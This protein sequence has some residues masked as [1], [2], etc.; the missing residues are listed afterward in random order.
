[1]SLCLSTKKRRLVILTTKRLSHFIP[2]DLSLQEDQLLLF[3]QY[4]PI[5]QKKKPKRLL[6]VTTLANM[7]PI[8]PDK[9]LFVAGQRKRTTQICPIYKMCTNKGD[10]QRLWGKLFNNSHFQYTTKPPVVV[11]PDQI[12]KFREVGE[13][14]IQGLFF[15]TWI[16]FFMVSLLYPRK[17]DQSKEGTKVQLHNILLETFSEFGNS[18]V[19]AVECR[20]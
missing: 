17:C 4:G 18:V 16:A 1:M 8:F 5:C 12:Q 14:G 7:S 3:H 9:Q 11:W 20:L 2:E 6:N 10:C 13:A 15:T 19:C